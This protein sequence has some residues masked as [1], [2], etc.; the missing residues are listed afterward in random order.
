MGAILA[1]NNFGPNGESVILPPSL[2]LP[3]H[4]GSGKVEIK[5]RSNQMF[6]DES[7]NWNWSPEPMLVIFKHILP[8]SDRTVGVSVS[9][10]EL[11][12]E[13]D[14]SPNQIQKD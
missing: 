4:I 14:I 12:L 6:Q 10:S 13:E 9:I 11:P 5:V 7:G 1:K 3:I 8:V 2:L